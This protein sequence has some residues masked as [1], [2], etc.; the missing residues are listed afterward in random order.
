MGVV[1]AGDSVA[2]HRALLYALLV[3]PITGISSILAVLIAYASEV[4]PTKVRSRATGAAAAA[5]KAGG[6]LVIA[7]VAASIAIPS[8]STTA[9]LGAIPMGLAALA[10]AVFGVETR[11]R[12]LEEIT[13][14]ELAPEVAVG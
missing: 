12:R 11:R 1:V 2:H 8:I 5:S 14:E 9:L 13:A 4:Y 3:I 10:V 7:I 6:V